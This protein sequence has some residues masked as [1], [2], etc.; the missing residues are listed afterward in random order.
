MMSQCDLIVMASGT[1]TLEAALL[2]VP[3]I[4]VYKVSFLSYLLGRLMIRVPWIGLAN[5]VAGKEVYPELIQ[6]KATPERVVETCLAL[7][8]EPGRLKKVREELRHIRAKLGVPGASK[9][10]AEVIY[11]YVSEI[12]S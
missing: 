7:I 1:A 6:Y 12:T 4:I 8:R 10:T 5:I 2:E 3:A 11:R 9:R